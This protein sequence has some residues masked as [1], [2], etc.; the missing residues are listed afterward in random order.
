MSRHKPSSVTSS[1]DDNK[2][3]SLIRPRKDKEEKSRNKSKKKDKKKGQSKEKAPSVEET[4][5]ELSYN[6]PD[7]DMTLAKSRT[8]RLSGKIT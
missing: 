1:R 3:R 8:Q 6:H 7:T 2:R 5:S 4:P